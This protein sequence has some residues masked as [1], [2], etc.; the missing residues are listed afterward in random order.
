MA[1]MSFARTDTDDSAGIRWLHERPL[2]T[3]LRTLSIVL[4]RRPRRR[5]TIPPLMLVA[6]DK[7]G[8][9][10]SEDK[11]GAMAGAGV[12][13]RLGRDWQRS[14]RSSHRRTYALVTAAVGLVTTSLSAQPRGCRTMVPPS[15]RLGTRVGRGSPRRSLRRHTFQR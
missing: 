7:L 2:L 4:G 15:L 11:R 1:T 13:E 10:V 14:H 5:R 8:A 12:A 6:D 9:H 3:A